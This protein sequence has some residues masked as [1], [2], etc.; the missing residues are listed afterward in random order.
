MRCSLRLLNRETTSAT[1]PSA[2]GCIKARRQPLPS[3]Y[4][5]TPRHWFGE[6]AELS[7]FRGNSG[8]Q[9]VYKPSPPSVAF[10]R[11]T[12]KA[13]TLGVLDVF[14]HASTW[15][16]FF[17]VILVAGGLIITYPLSFMTLDQHSPLLDY[18]T[19]LSLSG[20]VGTVQLMLVLILISFN[21]TVPI[22]ALVNYKAIFLILKPLMN[23]STSRLVTVIFYLCSLS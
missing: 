7:E 20:L 12:Q 15:S 5:R 23:F 2:L 18:T 1:R 13:N 11:A 3:Q 10:P 4:E 16:S 9:N 8:N 6:P 21:I 19:H 22:S 17:W 14:L